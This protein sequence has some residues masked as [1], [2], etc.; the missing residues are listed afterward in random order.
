MKQ[1]V[2]LSVIFC[3][4]GVQAAPDRTSR[5]INGQIANNQ[6]SNAYI[7]YT[8]ADTFGYF[9]GGTI[10]SDRHILTA[11]L[12]IVGFVRWDVGVGSNIFTQL[13]T[14]TSYTAQAHPSYNSANRAN[15]I[16]VI[17]LPV[18]LV[19]SANV[20]PIALPPLNSAPGYPFENEQGTI[21]G[22]G[23]TDLAATVRPSY[24]MRATQR[25]ISN[26]RCQQYYQI[27]VPS[28]FCAED[29]VERSN[30]CNG[31]LGAGFISSING[32]QTVTGIASLITQSCGNSYPA[33][34][35]RVESH[36]SWIN[37]VTG[38]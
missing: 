30:V 27:T 37:S 6:P 9:G 34:Y 23:F 10:I 26:T 7:L 3:V 38:I 20:A 15:D 25:V 21:V 29:V 28:Q 14:V 19:I 16:G 33:G 32:Q 2:L 5:I 8:R 13:G 1:L 31:D 22:F 35:T 36:R 11:A 17:T 24:L 12:N 4:L 18:S